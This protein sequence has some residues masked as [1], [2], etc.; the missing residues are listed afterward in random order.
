MDTDNSTCI[1]NTIPAGLSSEEYS[2]L[3][4]AIKAEKKIKPPA[5][6]PKTY[7]EPKELPTATPCPT[8]DEEI[9][10]APD[11]NCSVGSDSLYDM[12]LE[13]LDRVQLPER[14]TNKEVVQLTTDE[15]KQN[16]ECDTQDSCHEYSKPKQNVAAEQDISGLTCDSDYQELD[17]KTLSLPSNYETLRS[18]RKEKLITDSEGSGSQHMLVQTSI[19]G[20]HSTKGSHYEAL[21]LKSMNKKSVYEQLKI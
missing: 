15:I 13:T 8:A 6:P 2:R 18:L 16:S 9:Q 3:N 7:R 5:I 20:Q 11:D 21:Q 4:V 17:T 1:A 12:K 19:H 14:C 10:S